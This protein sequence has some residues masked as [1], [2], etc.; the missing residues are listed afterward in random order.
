MRI[1]KIKALLESE[2]KVPF[3]TNNL[4]SIR[5]ITGFD[6]SYAQLLFVDG[7]FHFITDG[8]YAE[9][10]AGTIGSECCIH[11]QQGDGPA[12][13]IAGILSKKR[14]KRLFVEENSLV[15]STHKNLSDNLS[16]IEL[17]DAGDCIDR[18]RMVK[19][20]DELT[21]IRKAAGIADNCLEHLTHFIR[22]GMTEWD[23]SVEIEH[24]Y[25]THGCRKSSFDSIVASGAGSS[26]PHYIPSMTKHV[27]PGSPLMV[28]MGCLF[29]DYN[30]DLTRTFFIDSVTDEFEKI[31]QTV[32]YA[33]CS[34][35]KAVAPGKLSGDVDAVA[36][37]IISAAGYGEQ[38]NHSLGHGVGLQVHELPALRKG[39]TEVL[40]SGTV[41]TVEPGI[42]IPCSGG[43][44]IE[45]MVLVTEAGFEILT[46]FTKELIIL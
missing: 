38:F 5:Y 32:L 42:Y 43:I 6:G 44:R 21:L 19:D 22:K 15:V 1:P 8:R 7:V 33:Q 13:I 27:E 40:V 14:E 35:V 34:A 3:Y 17:C 18:V 26:M 31:Y 4:V 25:R 11:I 46:S 24:F 16:G 10:A 20:A 41:V 37:D 39:G 2:N 23:I 45:D 36:R 30:S 29:E 12:K 9:Y 28:D